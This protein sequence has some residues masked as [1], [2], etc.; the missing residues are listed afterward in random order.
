[1]KRGQGRSEKRRGWCGK[2]DAGTMLKMCG[3]SG[4]RTNARTN[5]RTDNQLMMTGG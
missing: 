2:D 5:A 4:E 3:G 1:M